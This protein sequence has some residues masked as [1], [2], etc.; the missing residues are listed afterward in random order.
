MQISNKY[1]FDGELISTHHEAIEILEVIHA[2]NHEQ[3]DLFD[4]GGSDQ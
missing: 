3:L 1:D 2:P 4:Q